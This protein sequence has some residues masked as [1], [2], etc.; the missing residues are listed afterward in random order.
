[1]PATEWMRRLYNYRR[2]VFD[3]D[4]SGEDLQTLLDS[5]LLLAVYADVYYNEDI[6]YD[7]NPY[8][9]LC[10]Y[11]FKTKTEVVKLTKNDRRALDAYG[12]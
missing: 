2:F 11:D 1:M 8:G 6:R 7:E 4:E 5:R 10:L 3:L 12:N 9:A